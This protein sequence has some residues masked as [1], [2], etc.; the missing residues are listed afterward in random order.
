MA[1]TTHE[2]SQYEEREHRNCSPACAEMLG[3]NC[4]GASCVY[5]VDLSEIPFSNFDA[6][7]SADRAGYRRGSRHA[8]AEFKRGRWYGF[9][10]GVGACLA[11]VFLLALLQWAVTA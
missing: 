11:L 5:R 9:W 3:G 7:A 6:F 1:S 8:E 4:P 10:G 2:T